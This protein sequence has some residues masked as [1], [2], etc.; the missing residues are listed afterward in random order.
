MLTA[1]GFTARERIPICT[2]LPGET[3]RAELRNVGDMAGWT[4]PQDRNV[5][6]GANPVS[7]HVRSTQKGGEADVTRMR[8]LFADLDVKLGKCLDTLDQ[9]YAAVGGLA[10]FLDVE[11]VALI[12]SGH[13]LQPLWRVGSPP[14]DSNVIDRDWPRQEFRETWWR[15]GAVA[16]RKAQDAMWSPDG[17]QNTRTIDG[18]FNIDRVLRCPGSIN[19]K[20]PDDPVPVYTNLT[21]AVER[22]L[23]RD[24]IERFDHD[25]IK[26]L[27]RTREG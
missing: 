1:L 8:T 6:F 24:V 7:R 12:E 2:Q 9:C 5:W 19:W 23:M 25:G 3:F 17:A 16:Q 11:P 13:G 4:P 18:V 10:E 27:K 20:N 15:F 14:G 22:V 21:G 26:P